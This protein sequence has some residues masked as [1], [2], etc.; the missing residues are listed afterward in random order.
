MIISCVNI[1]FVTVTHSELV[2]D[3]VDNT[4]LL[5]TVVRL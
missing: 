1:L 5:G 3:L 2:L 4:L